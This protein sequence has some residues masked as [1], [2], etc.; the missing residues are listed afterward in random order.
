MKI[1]IADDSKIMRTIIKKNLLNFNNTL[2]IFEACN[3]KDALR[4]LLQDHD[5]KLI[6]LDLKMPDLTGF[7]VSNYIHSKE[8]MRDVNIIAMSADLSDEN[9]GT[10]KR[11]GV[12]YFLS[13]P[14]DLEKFNTTIAPIFEALHIDKAEPSK[15]E[16]EEDE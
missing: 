5:L 15:D 3:G 1:L 14:F 6:F 9:V 2:E 4:M 7:D 12:K 10:F 11:L 8:G 13:K 16:M